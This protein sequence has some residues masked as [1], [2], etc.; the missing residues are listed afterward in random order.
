MKTETKKDL[1]KQF[2]QAVKSLQECKAP[3]SA[4]YQDYQTCLQICKNMLKR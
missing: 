3:K 4:E 2:Q 1:S